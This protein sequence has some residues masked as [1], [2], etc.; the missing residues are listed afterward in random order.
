VIIS[1]IDWWW[2]SH[3]ASVATLAC[4]KTPEFTLKKSQK[5]IQ[6]PDI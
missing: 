6:N 1:G 2:K 5:K 4:R 3:T